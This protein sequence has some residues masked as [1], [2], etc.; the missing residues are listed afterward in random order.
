VCAQAKEDDSPTGYV[1]LATA[2]CEGQTVISGALGPL[3]V[4]MEMA[5]KAGARRVVRLPISIGSHSPLM[6]RASRGMNELLQASTIS[7][8]TAPMVGN[9][10]AAVLTTADEVY[11][12]LRDQL[13]MGVQ[14]QA[15]V[16]VM[17]AQGADMF[18]EVG[19]GNV[20]TRLVRRIDY[21]LNSLCISDDYEGLLSE[22]FAQVEA[23]AE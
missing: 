4:A 10:A 12:E 14:W 17:R 15:S 22:N 18:I 2:N 9:V 3:K 20:L 23:M 13:L 16:D 6:A 19:P 7:A 5:E 8:P 1:G 11:A 21:E